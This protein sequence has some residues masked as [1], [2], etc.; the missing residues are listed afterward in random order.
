MLET[1]KKKQKQKRWADHME[2]CNMLAERQFGFTNGKT[3]VANPISYYGRVAETMQERGMVRQISKK[4]LTKLLMKYGS[5]STKEK[6]RGMDERLPKGKEDEN[7]TKR[8][9]LIFGK[10]TLE[11]SVVAPFMLLVRVNILKSLM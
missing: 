7:N 11:G 9:K 6:D 8:E 4:P 5:W 3:C 1:L 2:K 10:C